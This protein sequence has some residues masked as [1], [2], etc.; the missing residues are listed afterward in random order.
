MNTIENRQYDMLLNVREFGLRNGASFP[1]ESLGGKLFA[2][3]V[4]I[5]DELGDHAVDENSHQLEK[6]GDVSARETAREKV[7]ETMKMF[8]RTARAL[9]VTRPEVDRKFRVPYQLGQR[10]LIEAAQAFITA[11]EPLMADFAEFE[12]PA[13]ALDRLRRELAEYTSFV[14]KRKTGRSSKTLT[15][16]SI[17]DAIGRGLETVRQLDA[18]V[19]NKFEKNQ[20]V[21]TEWERARTVPRAQRAARPEAAKAAT[22]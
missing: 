21:L 1:A 17:D 19:R 8:S 6:V 5:T 4:E 15:T 14:G 3:V 12:L 22:A 10:Q 20:P 7:M 9:A 13:D 2:S 16:A 11:A 18:I